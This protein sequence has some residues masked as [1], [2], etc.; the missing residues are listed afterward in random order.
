MKKT[1]LGVIALL[2]A[3]A[4][5]LGAF[6]SHGLKASL[7]AEQLNSFQT[8]IRY[9]FYHVFFL[10][11]V[12]LLPGISEKTKSLIYRLVLVGLLLFSGSIYL[13]STKAVT[14]IDISAVGWITPIGGS[15]LIIA[16][17]VLAFRYFSS[18]S[19]T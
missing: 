2:G 5:V 8:G 17:F 3:L 12:Y 4:V 11:V 16:W 9:Q 18:K 10:F 15:L 19:H 14:G 7:E 6:A 1:A 13:L